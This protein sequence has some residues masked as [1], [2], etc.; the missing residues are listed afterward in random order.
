MSILA[1]HFALV[2]S[3]EKNSFPIGKSWRIP[4]PYNVHSGIL[5]EWLVDSLYPISIWTILSIFYL[6]LS[7]PFLFGLFYPEFSI[8][9]LFGLVPFLFWLS[10]PFWFYL[11]LSILF[12]FEIFLSRIFYPFSIW[13]CPFSFLTFIS[14][15]LFGHLY[16]FLSIL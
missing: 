7:I 13:A 16:S 6:E 10:Y 15:F 11:E 5:A 3:C 8:P 1:S 2:R 12:L 4:L 14:L 9:F